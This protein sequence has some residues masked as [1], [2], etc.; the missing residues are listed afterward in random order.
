MYVPSIHDLSITA[1][2]LIVNAGGHTPV[3]TSSRSWDRTRCGGHITRESNEGGFRG[4]IGGRSGGGSHFGDG[5]RA[6]R[7]REGEA[8]PFAFFP[9]SIQSKR[10][11]RGSGLERRGGMVE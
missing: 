10:L 6:E 4:E 8:L 1:S 11:H 9:T 3:T 7:S 5:D 2:D